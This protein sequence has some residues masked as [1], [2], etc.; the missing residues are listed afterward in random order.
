MNGYRGHTVSYLGNFWTHFFSVYSW[1][2]LPKQA[3]T[4]HLKIPGT[5]SKQRFTLFVFCH[6]SF[7]AND[8][9]NYC[10]LS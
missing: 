4:P 7:F 2:S 6:T 8:V 1:M 5:K 9:R 3:H 10:S